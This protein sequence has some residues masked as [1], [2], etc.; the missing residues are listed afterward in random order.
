MI[1]EEVLDQ[2]EILW[3]NLNDQELA[4]WV[5][6]VEH[7]ETHLYPYPFG[8]SP[9]LLRLAGKENELPGLEFTGQ[10]DI[11]KH[12]SNRTPLPAHSVKHMKST[13]DRY[14]TS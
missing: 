9:Y 13:A 5:Q 4:D 12:R 2:V 3:Y 8:K 6:A 10:A 11:P 1:A 7:E 14:R